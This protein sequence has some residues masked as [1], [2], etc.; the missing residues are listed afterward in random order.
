MNC[1]FQQSQ[2]R[3]K[4]RLRK[5]PELLQVYFLKLLK[6]DYTSGGSFLCLNCRFC[7]T[8][9]IIQIYFITSCYQNL[10]IQ[11]LLF[12]PPFFFPKMLRGSFLWEIKGSR[13]FNFL[14]FK[15]ND[16]N[17]NKKGPAAASEFICQ[18]WHFKKMMSWKESALIIVV[19][20]PGS[21]RSMIEKNGILGIC[22]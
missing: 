11:K 5:G 22:I 3:K 12:V 15:N 7:C 19:S 4:I 13:G 17:H 21:P 9:S 1:D 14:Y 20:L 2:K 6:M 16:I 18:L 8:W 10:Q